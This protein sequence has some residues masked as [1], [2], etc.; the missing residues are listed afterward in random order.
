MKPKDEIAAPGP[1]VSPNAVGQPTANRLLS[2]NCD[3]E[4]QDL[5]E[6]NTTDVGAVRLNGRGETDN[7]W[8][9]LKSP[10]KDRIPLKERVEPSIVTGHGKSSWMDPG[11]SVRE[12]ACYICE[13][14]RMTGHQREMSFLRHLMLY[15]DT[16]EHHE[17]EEKVSQAQN[18]ERSARRAV[19]LMAVLAA[20]AVVGLGYSA[21]LVEDFPQNKTP[22][23]IR[24]FCALGLA[25]LVSLLTFAAL[26]L[27]SVSELENQREK[28]RRLVTRIVESRLGKTSRSESARHI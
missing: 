14:A 21:I 23:L 1:A 13:T 20:M 26:W 24:I 11:L 9:P 4:Q 16:D 6:G 3:L 15:D 10:T 22:L 18:K 12:Q 17:L 8:Q 7:N 19:W 28:C 27:V 25:S 2:G 5:I